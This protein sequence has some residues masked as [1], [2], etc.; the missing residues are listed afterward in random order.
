MPTIRAQFSIIPLTPVAGVDVQVDAD[1]TTSRTRSV[2]GTAIRWPKETGG[3]T[4]VDDVDVGEVELAVTAHF[5]DT[6]AWGVGYEGRSEDLVAAVRA[7]QRAKARCTVICGN[8]ILT[9][10]VVE[11]LGEPRDADTGDGVDVDLA[12]VRVEVGALRLID[13]VPDGQTQAL[14]Q[15]AEIGWL[16]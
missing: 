7:I 13:A 16:P 1:C 11:R 14:G 5:T 15:V 12:M 4:L 9:S 2:P 6:P 3:E 10:M 8:E